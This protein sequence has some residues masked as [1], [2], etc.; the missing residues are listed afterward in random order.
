MAVVA[1]RAVTAPPIEWFAAGRRVR[2]AWLVWAVLA[3]AAAL[4]PLLLAYETLI[5]VYLLCAV[6]AALVLWRPRIGVY[7]AFAFVL[8]FE[9]GGPDLMMEPGAYFARG[10]SSTMGW[11][12]VAFSPL[13]L[14][15]ALTASSILLRAALAR[16]RWKIGSA[17]DYRLRGG[18]LGVPVA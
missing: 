13:E 5:P 16:F 18:S 3:A 11:Q 4:A 12:R 9:V 6:L 1:A 7:F 8:L 17:D 2:A 15:L 14:L 10:L